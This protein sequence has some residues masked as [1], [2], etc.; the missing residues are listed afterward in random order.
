MDELFEAQKHVLLSEAH[1]L[2]FVDT[3][4]FLDEVIHHHE[5]ELVGLAIT[6]FNCEELLHVMKHLP[7]HVKKAVRKLLAK[8]VLVIVDVP[9]RP[10]EWKRE[11]SFV[12]ETDPELL[13]V[14]RDPSDAVL[15][16]VALRTRS[17]VLTKDKHHLF[18]VALENHLREYGLRVFKDMHSYKRWAVD[19]YQ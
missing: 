11:R 10:G 14:V 9:V 13:R 15:L 8:H 6:S 3:C 16:A 5:D 4:F 17:V 1:G 19:K 2:V 12:N 18:T 7:S